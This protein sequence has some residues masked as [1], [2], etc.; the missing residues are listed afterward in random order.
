MFGM[1]RSGTTLLTMMVGAHPQIVM[2]LSV[3]GMWFDF[4]DRLGRDYGGLASA[5]D[6]DRMVTDVIN[7]PRIRL[8]ET[9]LDFARIRS[10]TRLE[11]YPSLVAAVYQECAN[12]HDKPY[13]ASMDIGTL[14]RMHTVHDWFPDARFLHIVRDG[15]DVA[16]SH[17]T[18]PF[19]AGNI[20]ECAA[21]WDRRISTNMRMGEMLSPDQYMIL[22]FE[23][24]IQE[25]EKNLRSV[26]E[27]IGVGYSPEMLCYA[28]TV[29]ERVP[30]NKLWLWPALKSA[31]KQEK[32]GR[33][34]KEM[35]KAQRIVFERTAGDLLHELGY[36]TLDP[37][38]S[39]LSAHGLELLYFLDQGGRTN[40]LLRKLGIRRRSRL[41]R[42]AIRQE[43][44]MPGTDGADNAELQRTSFN[45][46]VE[47]QVYAGG[48]KHAPPAQSFVE[49][50]FQDA[51]L[52]HLQRSSGLNVIDAG[53]GVGAWLK[54]LSEKLAR[55]PYETR[56]CGFDIADKMVSLAQ[57][58]LTGIASAEDITR[59]DLLDSKAYSR[60]GILSGYDLI[61]TYDTVQQ[62]P[63]TR[64]FDA[65]RLMV[66]NLEQGGILVIFD[67]D[68][69]SAYGRKMACKKFLTRYFRLPLVP[70]YYCNAKYPPLAVFAK[71]LESTLGCTTHIHVAPDG[72]KRALV[73]VTGSQSA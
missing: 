31:P 62:L 5:S 61:F 23:D 51:V 69:A 2:P 1:E 56:I 11:D 28:E 68:S 16:L 25:P 58:E 24:L 33:W 18:M 8:W 15:R 44:N 14:R 47:T 54:F 10:A 57:V 26:C 20:A 52:P 66:E 70:R 35:S 60:P 49:Q 65:C 71:R 67:H 40:R 41:E 9:P 37:K 38:T 29:E 46:L 22:H 27:F 7:H 12:Q 6:C 45:T 43:T 32:V 59:G 55:E 53:C 30:S 63:P 4:A 34:K 36:E 64:Q 21:A 50:V 72:Q 13:W 19:G 17:Q 42:A 39:S 73:V 3:T 48:F